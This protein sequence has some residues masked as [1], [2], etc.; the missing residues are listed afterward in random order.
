MKEQNLSKG[1]VEVP[2]FPGMED[3]EAAQSLEYYIENGVTLIAK[4]KYEVMDPF[5]FM[6]EYYEDMQLYFGKL[7]NNTTIKVHW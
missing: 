7:E 3:S 6:F 1:A 5:L 4:E 2:R